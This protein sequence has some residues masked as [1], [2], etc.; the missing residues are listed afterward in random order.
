MNLTSNYLVKI[1][2]KNGFIYNRTKGSHKI[3]FNTITNKTVIV[4][5]LWK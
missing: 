4:P 1:L 3:Y 5:F 2:L